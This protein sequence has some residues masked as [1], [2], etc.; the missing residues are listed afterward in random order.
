MTY[1]L[2]VFSDIFSEFEGELPLLTEIMLKTADLLEGN[3]LIILLLIFLIIIL[4]ILL[5]ADKKTEDILKIYLLKIP[6]IGEIYKISIIARLS[7]YMAVIL[8]SG[9]G[10][11]ET[12]KMAADMT[13]NKAY[14]EFLHKSSAEISQ[15]VS[16]VKIFAKSSLIPDIFYYFSAVG[17][18]T[19]N[20]EYMME[21]AGD[22]YYELLSK[23][24]EGL[25]Q[26]L[27]PSLIFITAVCVGLISA[28]V[29][30]PMFQLYLII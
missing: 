18:E 6:I 20:L 21:K 12:L 5:T 30:M 27:E 2:P 22:Y 11:V 26:Y 4:L 29:I 23:K 8:G 28:A 17:A 10:L 14:R 15:G 25:L 13:D 7:S 9:I 1:I 24:T 3:I 19:G 16:P